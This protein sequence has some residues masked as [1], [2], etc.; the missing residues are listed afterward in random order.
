[1]ADEVVGDD[2]GRDVLARPQLVYPS[3]VQRFR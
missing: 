3:P 2:F 1:M